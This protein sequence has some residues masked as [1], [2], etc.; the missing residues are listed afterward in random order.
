MHLGLGEREMPFEA[1]TMSAYD[2][3]CRAAEVVVVLVD[4]LLFLLI[5]ANLGRDGEA[6]SKK[7]GNLRRATPQLQVEVGQGKDFASSHD[8]DGNNECDSM[9]QALPTQKKNL[10]T[11]CT[12][13]LSPCL[14]QV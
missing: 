10:N 6:K 14:R 5:R 2:D 7:G 4:L 11:S 9:R 8:D 12:A 13:L 3:A 1:M